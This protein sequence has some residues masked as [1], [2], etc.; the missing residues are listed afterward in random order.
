MA[1]TVER[2]GTSGESLGE[3]RGGG[4][5][6]GTAA[7][8]VEDG[9][10]LLGGGGVRDAEQAGADD[11]NAEVATGGGD[12]W[13]RD[14]C[15]GLLAGGRGGGGGSA[16]GGGVAPHHVDSKDEMAG[17]GF[18]GRGEGAEVALK[19]DRVE[20]AGEE[21]GVGDGAV[22]AGGIGPAGEGEGGLVEVALRDDAGGVDE[23]LVVRAAGGQVAVEMGGEADGAEIGEDDGVGFGEEAC[24]L[25]R[26]GE[27][28][29]EQGDNA[30]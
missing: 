7:R 8:V 22:D 27:A 19:A 15:G 18:G 25:R 14:H 26:A 1:Q 11:H 13:N 6:E 10:D 23:L 17:V 9:V 12:A 20:A 28:P 16:A 4:R 3:E 21:L 29:E 5:E 30:E 24:D 2:R